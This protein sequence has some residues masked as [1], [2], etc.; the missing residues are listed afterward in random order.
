MKKLKSITI[1]KPTWE[2]LKKER[3]KNEN[4]TIETYNQ[5][6]KRLIKKL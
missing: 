6:V 4:G 3:I 5:L 1:D 2:Q